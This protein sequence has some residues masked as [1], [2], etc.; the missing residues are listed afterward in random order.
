[1]KLQELIVDEIDSNTPP[2]NAESTAKK[3][4]S[5]HTLVDT[6]QLRASVRAASVVDGKEKVMGLG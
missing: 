2:P 1:M 6:G 3:K 5:S 4:G